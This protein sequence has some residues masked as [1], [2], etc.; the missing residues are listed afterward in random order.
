MILAEIILPLAVGGTYTYRL[1]DDCPANPQPG[2]R[3]LVPLGLKKIHTG[4]IRRILTEEPENNADKPIVYKPILCF[5]DA[6]PI[7]TP[8][9][10]QLWD[11]L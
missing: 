3:V 6:Y 1:P 7:V 11:W 9:Q 4:I 8:L 5:L 2:M 10:L